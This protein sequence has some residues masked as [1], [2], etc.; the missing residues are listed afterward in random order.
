[1]TAAQMQCLLHVGHALTA[2]RPCLNSKGGGLLS[3]LALVAAAST[4]SS[5]VS[6]RTGCACRFFSCTAA[7]ALAARQLGKPVRVQLDRHEDMQIIG[8]RHPFYAEYKVCLPLLLSQRPG[9]SP[10]HSIQCSYLP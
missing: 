6:H 4:L 8:H 2:L 10:C 5:H 1:M 9:C 3:G 7:A